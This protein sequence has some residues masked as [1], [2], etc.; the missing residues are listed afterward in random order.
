MVRPTLST[1]PAQLLL[2]VPRPVALTRYSAVV[3]VGRLASLTKAPFLRAARSLSLGSLD[4]QAPARSPQRLGQIR[5]TI[6][7]A[8]EQLTSLVSRNAAIHAVN[9]ER[10]YALLHSLAAQVREIGGIVAKLPINSLRR[11]FGDT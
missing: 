4:G 6:Y 8:I 11:N 1:S 9:E 7:L 5:P 2:W 3:I 10:T